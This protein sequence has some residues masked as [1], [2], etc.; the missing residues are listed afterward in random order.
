[1]VFA[2][3]T[4]ETFFNEVLALPRNISAKISK[5]IKKI[6]ENPFSTTGNGIKK[7]Q[8][9]QA[10]YR[11]YVDDN[12]RL[13]Y[14]VGNGWVTLLSVR[15]R[16][17][18][19][20]QTLDGV[21]IEADSDEVIQAQ[22]DS[23]HKQGLES[24]ADEP[25]NFPFTETKLRN[26]LIPSEYW[27]ALI[28]IDSIDSILDVRIPD[29]YIK[30]IIDIYYPS[31]ISESDS[32]ARFVLNTEEDLDKFIQGE[33]EEFL[34]KLDDKQKEIAE[35]QGDS[36]I[37][38]KGAPGTGKSTLALHRVKYLYSSFAQQKILFTTY[39][40]SLAN[41]SNQL[42]KVLLGN[43]FSRDRVDVKTVDQVALKYYRKNYNAPIFADDEGLLLLKATINDNSILSSSD[44][45]LIDKLGYQYIFE[46]INLVIEARGI[47]SSNDYLREQRFGR[48]YSLKESERKS[49]WLIYEA[50][51][52]AMNISG[53]TSK[54]EMRQKA[55]EIIQQEN[56]KD[57]DAVIIDEAQ[58]LSP[59]ALKMLALLVR[60]PRGLYLTADTSQSLYQR[61]FSWDYIQK[62]I[63]FQGT[64]R[65]LRQSY[66][67]TKSISNA[68]IEILENIG[69]PQTSIFEPTE[70]MKSIKPKIIL[71]DTWMTNPKIIKEFL[72]ESAKEYRLSV[73]SSAVLCPNEE[74][75][76]IISNQLN[77]IGLKAEYMKGDEIDIGKCC[78]KVLTLHSSKGL[79]FPFVAVVGLEEGYLPYLD[80]IPEKEK[81]EALKQ[82][83]KLFYVGSS[84]AMR[85]L[86]IYGSLSKS[87]QFIK[88]ILNSNKWQRVTL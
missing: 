87:S 48:Q 13:I 39:T 61:G 62:I 17:D 14:S 29:K 31:D 75:C 3:S 55:L 26:W 57:Y 53:Y 33:I 65:C 60:Y 21:F 40:D 68:C 64:T 18:C 30:R 19:Y 70:G 24:D 15:H 5:T 59:V 7:L 38:V 23:Q 46:E 76:Q 84:R 2:I 6:Q 35:L 28:N 69:D 8:N 63:K 54:G 82:Q 43:S 12:Y 32:Q 11:I 50:W 44:K 20:K 80:S 4:T 49:M 10:C 83:K 56:V 78:V 73:Y 88:P 27:E 34:L 45:K 41:Y 77:N 85:N 58:D 9:K 22:V 37:L 74:I 52:K 81:D 72:T 71:S 47:T 67:S 51:K 16:K 1:M 66:R 36:A 79:E 86:L 42:L 25:R